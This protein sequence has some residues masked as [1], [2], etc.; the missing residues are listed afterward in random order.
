MVKITYI[1]PGF[2]VAPALDAADFSHIAELG[3]KAVINNRPDGEEKG[4][5]PGNELKRHAETL[6]LAYR[7]VPARKSDIFT[8]PVVEAMADAL[9]SVQGPILAHC[10][11]GLRSA[12]VWAAASSRTVPVN[13]ILEA[14]ASA[15]FDLGF[16]RDDLDS[17]ADRARW[18]NPPTLEL[19]TSPVSTDARGRA[20][21]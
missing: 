8:D 16:I 12:I 6:G 14:L 17:Q 9:Q 7:H 1:T 18:N 20:A 2:A 21:A 19:E 4:Q 5:P 10:K 15:G 13:E 11:S 3:F